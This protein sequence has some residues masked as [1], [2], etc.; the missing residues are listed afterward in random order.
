M[1]VFGFT[2][3]YRY[4]YGNGNYFQMIRIVS[5]PGS[6]TE[7]AFFYNSAVFTLYFLVIFLIHLLEKPFG[8]LFLT[9]LPNEVP[10]EML[11]ATRRTIFRCPFYQENI[12]Q[13]VDFTPSLQ[14]V[15]PKTD[16]DSH[17]FYK[18]YFFVKF[19][20]YYAVYT[21]KFRQNIIIHFDH[22]RSFG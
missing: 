6:P 5:R 21:V 15:Y 20:H 13:T 17:G 3:T 11:N 12:G 4:W 19:D 22:R 1:S 10:G 18:Y 9:N 8:Y 14:P 7:Y 16:I 2:G